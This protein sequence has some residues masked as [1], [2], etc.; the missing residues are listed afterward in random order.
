M[1]NFDIIEL[2]DCLLGLGLVLELYNSFAGL[3]SLLVFEETDLLDG[4]NWT[5]SVLKSIFG[6]V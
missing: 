6:D 4:S 1:I 2:G 5:K 3:L